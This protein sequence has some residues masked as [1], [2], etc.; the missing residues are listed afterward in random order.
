[1]ATLQLRARTGYKQ[2][3]SQ[4]QL[5]AWIEDMNDLIGPGEKWYV[6]YVKFEW[7][8][9]HTQWCHVFYVEE[10]FPRTD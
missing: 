8:D 5:D 6:T 3:Y 1:M 4:Y 2:L 9:E 10:K 7:R